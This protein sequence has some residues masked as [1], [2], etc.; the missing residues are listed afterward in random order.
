MLRDYCIRVTFRILLLRFSCLLGHVYLDDFLLSI[1][2]LVQCHL[3]QEGFSD[4]SASPSKVDS[5]TQIT[6]Y[7]IILYKTHSYLK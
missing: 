2:D 3:L 6:L 4:Y 7:P 5:A 1:Q